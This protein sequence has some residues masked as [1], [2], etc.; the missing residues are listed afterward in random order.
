MKTCSALRLLSIS[1]AIYISTSAANAQFMR[2]DQPEELAP[3]GPC[4]LQFPSKVPV[5]CWQGLQ[6]FVLPQTTMLRSYG[7]QLFNGGT[8][9]Y[10]HASYDDLA[11][12]TLTVTKTEPVADILDG[13]M[14]NYRLT[15]TEDK[16]GGV[17]SIQTVN[18]G[19]TPDDAMV[20]N[21]VLFRDLTEARNHYLGKTYWIAVKRLPKLGMSDT[22]GGDGFVDYLKYSPVVITDVLA[23]TDDQNPIRMVVKNGQGEEGYF[24]IAVSP[25][26]RS[27]IGGVGDEAFAGWMDLSDPKLA[28]KWSPKIWDAIQHARAVVGMS[29]DMATMSWGKPNDINR[30]IVAGRV[31]EQ[32][33]YDSNSYLYFE[34]GILNAIQN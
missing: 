5:R 30:T 26:N 27:A 33:V 15:L 34:D 16:S 22:Y 25:T 8:G 13:T 11:G 24:D 23:S 31:H 19:R 10:G 3:A 7:Y 18:I 20:S 6:I 14:K 4:D 29:E 9:Q 32:W 2:P 28:H 1:V 12:K 21:V 17:F